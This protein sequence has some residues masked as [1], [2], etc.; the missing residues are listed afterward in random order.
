[1]ATYSPARLRHTN[2]PIID[3]TIRHTLT[4]KNFFSGNFARMKEPDRQPRVRNR[5]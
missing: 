3:R 1:M 5:K 4:A 2:R